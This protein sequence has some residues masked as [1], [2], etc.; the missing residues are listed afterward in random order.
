MTEQLDREVNLADVRE[1]GSPPSAYMTVAQTLPRQKLPSQIYLTEI[2]V[3]MMVRVML[4][5][6]YNYEFFKL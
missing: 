3:W 4:P 2:F 5:T 1:I 6:Y